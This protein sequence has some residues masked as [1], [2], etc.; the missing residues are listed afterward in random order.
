MEKTRG[1]STLRSASGIGCRRRSGAAVEFSPLGTFEPVT[2]YHA[3]G[4]HGLEAG[5]WTDDTS[6]ALALAAS[7]AEVGWNLT[8]Q[9]RR[10]VRWWRHG[11]YSVNGRCFDIGLTR[12]S[13]SSRFEAPADPHSSGSSAESA[14]GNGSIMR[15]SPVPMRFVHL[16][17]DRISEL[18]ALAAESSLPTHAS[19]QCLS[20]CRYLALILTGLMH[21][22]DRV[23]VLSPDWEP[24]Q[25]LRTDH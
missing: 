6:M 11:E 9:T 18:A 22:I 3:G 1:R 20:A 5:E 21:G 19:V 13:A 17:P 12:R 24:V 7:I 10:Y 14:S 15:L 16:F 23:E 25:R 4:P 8:D 2:G